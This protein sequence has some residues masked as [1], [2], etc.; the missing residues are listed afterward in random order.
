MI[1][2][3]APNI[4]HREVYRAASLRFRDK[5]LVARLKAGEADVMKLG[6]AYTAAAKRSELYTLGAETGVGEHILAGDMPKVYTDGL[7][8]KN[9]EARDFYDEIRFSSP[10]GICP[11]CNHR[12]V[13]TLDHFLPKAKY[14]AFSVLPHNLL[15]CCRD[16]NTDKLDVDFVD[17]EHNL[18]HPYFDRVD[19]F[20]WL[21]CEVRLEGGDPVADYY[22]SSSGVSSELCSRLLCHMDSLGLFEL[23]TVQAARE[24]NGLAQAMKQNYLSGGASAVAS[25]CETLGA[26]RAAISK[27]HWQA[28]LWQSAAA[29]DEFCSMVWY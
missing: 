26:S 20:K 7:L 19:D 6:L 24:I 4:S 14:E 9:S 11:M 8:R 15:P 25:F 16:C 23:Y 27:N 22:I 28:V 13:K 21:G 10:Q 18:L 17:A 1:P 29:S 5:K 2:L 12:D 3:K